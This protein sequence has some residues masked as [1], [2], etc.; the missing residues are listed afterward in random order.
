MRSLEPG[1][2]AGLS[3]DLASSSASSCCT[4]LPRNVRLQGAAENLVCSGELC[5]AHVEWQLLRQL[6]QPLSRFNP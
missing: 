2:F 1:G 6:P 3:R 5:L 4:Q